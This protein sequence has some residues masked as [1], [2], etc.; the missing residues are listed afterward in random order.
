MEPA[1]LN[2]GGFKPIKK[3][4]VH[5]RPGASDVPSALA[6]VLAV[7]KAEPEINKAIVTPSKRGEL[8]FPFSIL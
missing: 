3:K 4:N 7:A 1:F 6:V 5:T 2:N 8:F